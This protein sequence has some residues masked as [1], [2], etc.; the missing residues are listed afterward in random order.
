[1]DKFIVRLLL[2]LFPSVLFAGGP[3]TMSLAPPPGDISVIFLADIFG[4]VD[5]VLHGTGSQIMGAM[6]GIFNSAVLSIGGVIIMYTLL[7]STLNTAHQ[8]EVLGKEWSSIWIPLRSAVGLAL[9]IPKASGYCVMQ[10]FVMWIVVQGVGAA[11]KVWD[12]ALDYLNRGGVIVQSQQGGTVLTSGNSAVANGAAYLLASQ[13]CM[14]GVEQA[15]QIKRQSY[16]N[17]M[18]LGLPLNASVQDFANTPVPDFIGSVNFVQYQQANQQEGSTSGFSITLPNFTTGPYAQLNG[19]CGT[20]TWSPI[21]VTLNGKPVA[22]TTYIND[23]VTNNTLSN[24]DI[25]TAAMSRAIALQQMYNDLS[26]IAQVMVNNNPQLSTT[27][28]GTTIPSTSLNNFGTFA[29]SQ[30]GVAY[31]TSGV[32]CAKGLNSNCQTW[33]PDTS[34]KN[35]TAPIFSGTEL[36]G[37]IADYNGII[38]PTLNLIQQLQTTTTAQ[39]L[40]GFIQQAESQGW[41]A[42][43]S[44]F[45]Y[46]ANISSQNAVNSNATDIAPG[47][48][49]GN[50]FKPEILN[51]GFNNGQANCKDTAGP[52]GAICTLFNN[53]DTLIGSVM[54][55]LNYSYS[56]QPGVVMN[57]PSVLNSSSLAVIQG[58]PSSATTFAYIDNSLMVELP[59]QPGLIPPDFNLIINLDFSAGAFRLPPIHFSCGSTTSWVGCIGSTIANVLYNEILL[60]IYNVLLISIMSVINMVFMALMVIPLEYIAAMFKQN[61]TALQD[62]TANPI[63]ALAQMGINFINGA[64]DLWIQ[65]TVLEVTTSFIPILGDF[66]LIPLITMAL[67]LMMAWTGVMMGVGFVTAYYVPFLP[68]MI[69]LFGG[70]AWMMA[71][72]E[73]MVAAPIVALGVTHPEGHQA[74]GKGEHAV[75]I[76]MN[77]FLRPSMMII[78]YISAISLAYVSVWMLNSGF[79]QAMVFL[80][81]TSGYSSPLN[82]TNWAGLYAM[83]FSVLIYATIYLTVVQK[84]FTLIT[85]LPDKVLR[86]IGGQAESIGSESS[87]WAEEAKGKVSEMGKDTAQAQGATDSAAKSHLQSAMPKNKGT[88]DSKADAKGGNKSKSQDSSSSGG[89]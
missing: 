32:P 62:P 40:R 9:L 50:L 67:P 54:D 42:A 47:F 17:S 59:G 31:Q 56:S 72:I 45:F 60:T 6:F 49:D 12:A 18:A 83:F 19:L 37:A 5:N 39:S 3:P 24:G 15:L 57:V 27:N 22:L 8:G 48:P 36:Q 38:L 14:L 20:F 1:M 63:V 53:D 89:E 58:Q 44:Y 75:M 34:T 55:M 4:V 46:L 73:A 71:V 84:S 70:I 77:V 80:G 29:V 26:M 51:T 64:N 52:L 69:F 25:S 11:D 23:N 35:T 82:Y 87:Q 2:L 7:V 79:S 10:I 88:E 30:F 85:Y 61:I 74:F 81:G 86:W 66:L 68:F 76:L 41:L 43:G 21:T 33:G 65:T 13:V 78:G 28:G 16:Q